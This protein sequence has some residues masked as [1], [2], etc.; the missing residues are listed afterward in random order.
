MTE[1]CETIIFSLHVNCAILERKY[2]CCILIW[3]F[4][5]V[6]LVFTRPL[7]GKPNFRSYL[8]SQ[9]C[10]TR[11][12]REDLMYAKNMFYSMRDIYEGRMLGKSTRGRRRIQL[13]DD[14]LETIN[15]ADLKK[16][17]EDRSVWR[18]TRREWVC[19]FSELVQTKYA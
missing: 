18:T 16:A 12:I 11:E 8:I 5:S 19:M 2:F 13:V 4:L 1:Y 10:S 17:A 3:R 6:L 15:Y 14:L 9:F 7:M